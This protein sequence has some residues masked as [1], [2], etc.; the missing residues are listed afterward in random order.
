MKI[1]LDEREQAII[2]I[3]RKSNEQRK[4][5][6]ITVINCMLKIMHDDGVNLD[7]KLIDNIPLKGRII[8]FNRAK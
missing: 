7:L 8:P 4:Q 6:I 5:Y 3:Y 1:E 2:E